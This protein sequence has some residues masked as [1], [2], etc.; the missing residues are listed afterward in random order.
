[1]A[2]SKNTAKVGIGFGTALAIAMSWNANELI[3]WPILLSIL[4]CVYVIYFALVYYAL[5]R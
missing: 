1:M 2:G 4:P 3:L 5:V